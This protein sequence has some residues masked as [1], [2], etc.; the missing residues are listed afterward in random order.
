LLAGP[1]GVGKSLVALQLAERI[2]G[3]IISVDSMQAYRGMD[4]GTAKPSGEERSRIP[5]HLIDVVDLHQSFDAAQFVRL[6]QDAVQQIQARWHWP[7]LC[8]GTGLYFRAFLHGLGTSPAGDP[9][10]RAALEDKPTEELL[11]QLARM[12]PV[13]YAKID[14]H[15]R[16]RVL[17]ALEVIQ[18]TGKPFSIQRADW[19]NAATGIQAGNTPFCLIGLDRDRLNLQTRIDARVD[20]MFARGL[21]AETRA[22]LDLGLARN[23]TARQALGYRQVI[24]FLEGERSLEETIQLVKQKTRQY[25]KRQMTWFRHQ[26]DMHWLRLGAEEEI[27]SITQRVLARGFPTHY[28]LPGIDS[29]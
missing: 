12:D 15:N 8:G 16:R 26:A 13:M 29:Y 3:E 28:L 27:E 20:T 21:V 10:V 17:R 23:P 4:I 11:A 7:I 19:E 5:H 1:T 2:G 24:E 6:A 14:R 9:A 22:L 25:A 18:L